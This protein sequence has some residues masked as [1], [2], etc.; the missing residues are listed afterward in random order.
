[1]HRRIPILSR[2]LFFSALHLLVPRPVPAQSS[3]N[4]SD[5]THYGYS[6]AEKLVRCIQKV[7]GKPA[8]GSPEIRT[9]VNHEYPCPAT[10]QT[11][12]DLLQIDVA[13]SLIVPK[14]E[15]YGIRL[16]ETPDWVYITSA[17]WF[18]D[19]PGTP[20][21]PARQRWKSI[22]IKTYVEQEE[23]S[24]ISKAEADSLVPEILSSARMI[25]L[26]P[27]SSLL[28]YDPAKDDAMEVGVRFR[29]Y[30]SALGSGAPES[31]I[32]VIDQWPYQSVGR[33]VYGE[34][35]KGAYEMLWDSALLNSRGS[36]G[37]Q[38]VNGDGWNEIVWRSATCGAQNCIPQQIVIFDRNGRE[39]TRQQDCNTASVG[40]DESDGVCAIEGQGIQLAVVSAQPPASPN[41][42]QR[43]PKDILVANWYANGKD[44][45]FSLQN[46]M[47]VLN[48]L[49]A[50]RYAA[51]LAADRK[52]K[53]INE[54]IVLNEEGM[55]LMKEGHY[56]EAAEKFEA[57]C[58]DNDIALYANNY[59]FALYKWGQLDSAVWWFR[60]AVRLDP[61]RSVAYLNLGDALSQLGHNSEARDAYRQYLE[62]APN[63]KSAAE[64]KKKLDAISAVP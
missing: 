7:Y 56:Q 30:K 64:V 44:A 14:G 20:D 46:G 51:R 40:F 48:K 42:E 39:I 50:G 52:S 58:F 36:V 10:R 32:T 49:D 21:Y 63:S 43:A 4:N 9:Q 18:T 17:R 34:M 3:S 15:P 53:E 6:P 37:F 2:L 13:K 45:I 62:L 61:K 41:E 22:K 26:Q 27:P 28:P 38:D 47:Y 23:G 25:F 5:I 16:F 12:D 19:V 57:A 31:V 11:I 55:R 29:F 35:R 59:G 8:A 1:M 54:A 24:N 60:K 33:L